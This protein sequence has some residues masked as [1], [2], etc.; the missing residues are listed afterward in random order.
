MV[1]RDP[2][3][4]PTASHQ[5]RVTDEQGIM[6]CKHGEE[7]CPQCLCDFSEDNRI[8]R[9]EKKGDMEGVKAEQV[10]SRMAANANEFRGN[11]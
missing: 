7:T 6:R 1:D 3:Q 10:K 11:E 2:N 8:V 4:P 5:Q 9:G